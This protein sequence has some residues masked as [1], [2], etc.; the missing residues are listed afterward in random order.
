MT[1]RVPDGTCVLILSAVTLLQM[2]IIINSIIYQSYVNLPV[3]TATGS[4]YDLAK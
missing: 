3:Q 2:Q 1:Y 4:P